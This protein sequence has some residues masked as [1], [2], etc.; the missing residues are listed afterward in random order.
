MTIRKSELFQ[1]EGHTEALGQGEYLRRRMAV[2]GLTASQLA[3]EIDV[4]V[5]TIYNI[6]ASKRPISSNVAIKLSKYFGGTAEQWL[7]ETIL[8][9]SDGDSLVPLQDKGGRTEGQVVELSDT[10]LFAGLSE[11][12]TGI[13]VD[14]EI[15]AALKRPQLGLA[16][17]PYNRDQVEPASY[18]LTIGLIITRGFEALNHREW[19]ILLKAEHGDPLDPDEADRLPRIRTAAKAAQ[20]TRSH[21]LER[22]GSAVLMAREIVS[23]DKLFMA[24]VG[25]ITHNAMRGLL[26]SHGFQIDPGYAGPIFV[27][28]LN[29]GTGPLTLAGGEKLVSLAI[30]KLAHAPD[31]SYRDAVDRK[32]L[33]IGRELDRQLKGLFTVKA[34]GGGKVKATSGYGATLVDVGQEEVLNKA[35]GAILDDLEQP[36]IEVS[37]LVIAAV[38]DAIEAVTVEWDDVDALARRFQVA[39]KRA[40]DDAKRHFRQRGDRQTLLDTLERLGID[41]LEAVLKLLQN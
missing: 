41:P 21:S 31:K 18:D 2:K 20:F 28:A 9:D 26:V 15:D 1:P 36:R 17:A 6:T 38:R 40:L 11:N 4:H 13:L 22:L 24:D 30:R 32:V 14:R 8:V 10:P 19:Q 16:I 35:V 33:W 37:P 12:P 23:F 34:L 25:S 29:I 3:D 39:A 7:T 27:T 5:Q